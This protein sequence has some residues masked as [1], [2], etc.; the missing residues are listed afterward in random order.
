[1]GYNSNLPLDSTLARMPATHAW[2]KRGRLYGCG[3]GV[4]VKIARE[5]GYAI[6]HVVPKGS[7]MLVRKDVLGGTQVHE[8]EHWREATEL[9]MHSAFGSGQ[10]SHHLCAYE[11]YQKTKDFAQCSGKAVSD[12]LAKL[13]FSFWSKWYYW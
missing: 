13:G 6:V 12:Q 9:P 7:V 1:M 3:L 8:T 2:D 11:I 4:H 5:C 10:A